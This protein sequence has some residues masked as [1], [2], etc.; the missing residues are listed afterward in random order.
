MM[1]NDR[2]KKTKRFQADTVFIRLFL[3]FRNAMQP[4]Y[5]ALTIAYISMSHSGSSLF[6]HKHI[7]FI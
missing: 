3:F 1:K 7:F 5:I 2:L 6:M 4:F